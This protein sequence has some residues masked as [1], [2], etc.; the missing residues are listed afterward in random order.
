MLASGPLTATS[1]RAAN[2]SGVRSFG[3]WSVIRA[4]RSLGDGCWTALDVSCCDIV[5]GRDV[6]QDATAT[7]KGR[8]ALKRHVLFKEDWPSLRA[9][10]ENHAAS[11]PEPEKSAFGPSVI[12]RNGASVRQPVKLVVIAAF[13]NSRSIRD[14]TRRIAS[15]SILVSVLPVLISSPILNCHFQTPGTVVMVS[16]YS[17]PL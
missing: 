3:A 2:S 4:T 7:P 17:M 8:E 6:Q 11:V 10:G 12:A 13:F 14:C 16:V 1:S 15:R 9:S 5:S